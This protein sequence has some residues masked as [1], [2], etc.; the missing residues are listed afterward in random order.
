MC[1]SVCCAG[2]K[3]AH[4]KIIVEKVPVVH[5]LNVQTHMIISITR[6]LHLLEDSDSTQHEQK[7]DCDGDSVS[8]GLDAMMKPL[9]FSILSTLH[10][11]SWDLFG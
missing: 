9:L 2:G 10:V 5:L 1:N 8:V 6:P 11:H 7:A 4:P 3:R